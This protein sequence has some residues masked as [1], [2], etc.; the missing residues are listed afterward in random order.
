MRARAAYIRS[1]GTTSILVA[2]ALLMLGV[3]GALVGFHG[4]PDGAVG[5]TVPSVPLAPSPQPVLNAVRDVSTAPTGVHKGSASAHRASTAGLVK[6]VPV[7]SPDAIGYPE[8]LAPG[9]ALP[10]SGAPPTASNG[11]GQGTPT[12]SVQPPSAPGAPTD[13]SQVST[14]L[15]QVIGSLPPPPA[16]A[17]PGADSGSLQVNVPLVGVAVTVP[18]PS[19][20]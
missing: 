2:A 1:L 19:S 3:V 10:T 12:G 17:G 5:E 15:D 4:W 16:Q 14:L 9:H 13:P 8:A 20:R 11:G 7:S 18:P 6:V